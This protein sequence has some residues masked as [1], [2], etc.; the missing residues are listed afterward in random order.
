ME[1]NLVAYKPETISEITERVL[2]ILAGVQDVAES[3]DALM[4]TLNGCTALP[5]TDQWAR[6]WGEAV[7]KK[8]ASEMLRLS[9][10]QINKL[11]ARGELDVTPDRRILVRRAAE[12]ANGGSQNP[13]E[14]EV[15]KRHQS[16]KKVKM[17]IP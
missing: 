7:N 12:W 14:K 17:F 10:S 9:V 4:Q 8:T 11:I 16:R 5:I 1:Q 15:Q 13:K 6:T 3:V 2:T